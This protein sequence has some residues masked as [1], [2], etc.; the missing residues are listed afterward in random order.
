MNWTHSIG[1]LPVHGEWKQYYEQNELLTILKY[2]Y[3]LDKTELNATVYL[4]LF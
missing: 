2:V 4:W 1:V 3:Q